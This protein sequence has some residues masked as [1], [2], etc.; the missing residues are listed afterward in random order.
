M[1]LCSPYRAYPLAFNSPRRLHAC[2][3]L[4]AAHLQRVGMHLRSEADAAP[5]Y[6]AA[7]ETP[8]S[9]APVFSQSFG[10]AIVCRPMTRNA[11]EAILEAIEAGDD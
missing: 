8:G 7:C 5:Q 1:H 11:I 10:C 3:A 2:S 9:R 6:C 4:W